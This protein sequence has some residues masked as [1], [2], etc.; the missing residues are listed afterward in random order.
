MRHVCWCWGLTGAIIRA[1]ML[2]APKSRHN[3]IATPRGK[4]RIGQALLLAASYKSALTFKLHQWNRSVLC[5]TAWSAVAPLSRVLPPPS[6]YPLRFCRL[7]VCLRIVLSS[8]WRKRLLASCV[9][10][11]CNTGPTLRLVPLAT[12]TRQVASS[13]Q[14]KWHSP[15]ESKWETHCSLYRLKVPSD[16][17]ARAHGP[18]CIGSTS[19]SC[20]LLPPSASA[21]AA[22]EVAVRTGVHRYQCWQ[23]V[24]S[25]TSDCS[26]AYPPLYIVLY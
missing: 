4:L 20:R 26:F 16:A 19:G 14:A 6:C 25:A 13:F 5:G 23:C 12:S 17:K 3:L 8:R 11:T 18:D 21:A 9:S 15:S 10:K 2:S 24:P 7:L 1:W 22:A